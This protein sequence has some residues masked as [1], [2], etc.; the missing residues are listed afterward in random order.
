LRKTIQEALTSKK[1]AKRVADHLSHQDIAQRYLMQTSQATDLISGGVKINALPE[2]VYAVIVRPT[3]SFLVWLA[4]ASGRGTVEA[5][6]VSS[7]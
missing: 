1:A 6:L 3:P 2:K 4:H 5:F 7:V